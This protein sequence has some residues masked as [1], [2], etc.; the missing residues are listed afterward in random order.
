ML[1]FFFVSE[2]FGAHIRKDMGQYIREQSQKV[3]PYSTKHHPCCLLHLAELFDHSKQLLRRDFRLD[4]I[5]VGI[6]FHG[7]P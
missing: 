1:T 6:L 7:Q 2:K 3:L 5:G 4:Q